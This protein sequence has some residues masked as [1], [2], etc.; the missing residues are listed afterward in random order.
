MKR[1]RKRG[2]NPIKHVTEGVAMGATESM[3]VGLVFSIAGAAPK[4]GAEQAM[5]TATTA[6]S[7]SGLQT[8]M[9]GGTGLMKSLGMMNKTKRRKR[10]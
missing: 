4:D 9:H 8:M 10:K 7:L 1:K 3:G 6:T 2:F 5:K